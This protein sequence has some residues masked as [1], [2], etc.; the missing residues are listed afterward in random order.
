M[1]SKGPALSCSKGAGC[2]GAPLPVQ[3][4]HTVQI[5]CKKLELQ[6]AGEDKIPPWAA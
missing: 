2:V 6:S 5:L 1:L 4:L 3:T